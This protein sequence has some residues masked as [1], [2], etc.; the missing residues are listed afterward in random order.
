MTDWFVRSVVDTGRL[1]L[2]CFLVAFIGAFLF[3]RFSVRMIR[4]GVKWWPKN[5]TPGGLH[6]HHV[7]FGL[8]FV[9]VGGVG[10]LAVQSGRSLWAALAALL[11]GI[12]AALV[13]DEFAL[14]LHLEDVYWSERGRLS[15]DAV[16]LAVALT[17]LV[18]VG[19]KPLGLDDVIA[20]DGADPGTVAWLIAGVVLVNLAFALITL[21]KGKVWTGMIGLFVPTLAVFGALRIARPHSPWA[22]TRYREGSRKSRTAHERE[23]KVRVPLMRAKVAFQELLAGRFGS[24]P[25][26]PEASEKTYEKTSKTPKDP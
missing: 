23:E 13:L 11:F 24:A 9:M 26:A 22:R 10:G 8:V 16:F 5:V 7:V 17:S 12:G 19:I 21:A 1:R 20:P 25:K 15:V 14:V 6:I 18:L 3:I 4:A 2:F